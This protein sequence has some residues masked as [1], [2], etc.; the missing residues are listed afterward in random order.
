MAKFG[1]SDRSIAFNP[2]VDT[3]TLRLD[4]I[5]LEGGKA[6]GEDFL[7]LLD[8]MAEEAEAGKLAAES[9]I[10]LDDFDLGDVS[11]HEDFVAR[12]RADELLGKAKALMA[13]EE[14][15]EAQEPLCE[16]LEEVG[17]HHEATF[18]LAMCLFRTLEP[19]DALRT[20]NRL[21]GKGMEAT[22]EVHVGILRGQIRGVLQTTALLEN[23]VLLA[24]GE[25]EQ[26]ADKV[27]ELVGLDP[28][29]WLYHFLLA[30]NLMKAEK[31]DAAMT[32]I[33][34]GLEAVA[35]DDRPRLET[36]R[37]QV[38]M[39]WARG[40]MA[41]ARGLYR[42]GK[43]GAARSK[44]QHLDSSCKSTRLWQTFDGYLRLLDG[45]LMGT[46]RGYRG[47]SNVKPPGSMQEAEALYQFLV[48]EEMMSVR[49][50]VENED[51]GD[52]I[53]V[54]SKA[55]IHTPHYSYARFLLAGSIYRRFGNRI[56]SDDPP[57]LSELTSDLESALGHARVGAL[58]PEIRDGTHLLQE[59][60]KLLEHLRHTGREAD[61]VNGAIEEFHGI[62][63]S[64]KEG[65]SSLR[66]LKTVQSRLQKLNERMPM[67]RKAARS[68]N[69]VEAVGHL[70][71]ALKKHL[72]DAGEALTDLGSAKGE[73]KLVNGAGKEFASIMKKAKGGISSRRQLENIESRLEKLRDR[74]RSLQNKVKSSQSKK[75]LGDLMDAVNKNLR[76]IDSARSGG[77]GTGDA[78]MLDTLEGALRAQV[79]KME[80][81]GGISG[82]Q[83]RQEARTFLE[84]IKTVA[85]GLRGTGSSSESGQTADDLI[86]SVDSAIRRYL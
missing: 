66:Q 9:S 7:S 30:G 49:E 13:G 41:K 40:K 59:I 31:H 27:R 84:T 46:F 11:I 72:K 78:G 23:M 81:L 36:L 19:L 34:A 17:E 10:R 26:A 15:A 6:V 57:T 82:Y 80:S 50:S 38:E 56:T 86:D 53:I 47:P 33:Q 75:A 83:E 73:A 60:E 70:E 20:L 64:V 1:E 24:R 65:I 68:E 42:R 4:E 35:P 16:L 58:D 25:F 45:G 61:A 32:A 67:V 28:E 5:D 3:K 22:L 71:K 8:V 2:M 37:R 18:L 21:R 51:F 48:E 63:E 69:A 85:E 39:G 55:V 44:L 43:Y 52:A 29:E 77:G 54:L 79:E 14:F 12:G 76:Q 74:I 62:M